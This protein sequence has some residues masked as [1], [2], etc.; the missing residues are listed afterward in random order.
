MSIGTT[1]AQ[2]SPWSG[3][4]WLSSLVRKGEIVDVI[5][6]QGMIGITMR[7]K[8][9]ENGVRG[10]MVFL[11]NLE[12]NKEFAGEDRCRPRTGNILILEKKELIW[13]TEF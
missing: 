1:C 12:S 7:A 13:S 5:A 9:Q 3:R 6:Y 8:V 4:I 2:G 10:D 11:R